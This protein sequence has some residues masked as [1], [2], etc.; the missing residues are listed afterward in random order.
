MSTSSKGEQICSCFINHPSPAVCPLFQDANID[1]LETV[2]SAGLVA[3]N[4]IEA[5]LHA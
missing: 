1:Q 5:Y 3:S 4:A 2:K